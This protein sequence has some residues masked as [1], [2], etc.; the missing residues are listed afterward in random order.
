[1]FFIMH[2]DDQRYTEDEI[3]NIYMPPSIILVAKLFVLLIATVFLLI[4][5]VF[6]A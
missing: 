4:W 1:M 2:T 3:K 5:F 6:H